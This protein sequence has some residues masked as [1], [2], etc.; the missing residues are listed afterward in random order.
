M[1]ELIKSSTQERGNVSIQ[2]YVFIHPVKSS[3]CFT[4][5]ISSGTRS[6]SESNSDCE[7]IACSSIVKQYMQDR[8]EYM[9]L[10]YSRVYLCD[11]KCYSA[12]LRA[13]QSNLESLGV[14]E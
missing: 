8:V 10:L 14:I 4:S 12:L 9:I 2:I 3:S 5:L 11:F 1:K 7:Q 6:S 13:T